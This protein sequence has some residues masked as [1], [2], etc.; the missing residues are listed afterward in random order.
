MAGG[1]SAE[2]KARQRA[3]NKE[4]GNSSRSG[5]SGLST[6]LL[7]MEKKSWD[8]VS[9]LA[10]HVADIAGLMYSGQLSAA[11][12]LTLQIGTPLEYLHETADVAIAGRQGALFFRV[13]VVTPDALARKVGEDDGSE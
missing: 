8:E 4:A 2:G 7:D 11:G 12:T 9:E 5:S 1:P 6:T 3:R 10:E 13:Y